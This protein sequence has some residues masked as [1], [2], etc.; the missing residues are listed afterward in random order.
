MPGLQKK[1]RFSNILDELAKTIS[2]WKK[3]R[4][5]VAF[6]AAA[7]GG[8]ISLGALSEY[9]KSKVRKAERRSE[10]GKDIPSDL[11]DAFVRSELRS[12]IAPESAIFAKTSAL[13][14]KDVLTLAGLGTAVGAVPVYHGFRLSKDIEGRKKLV[15]REKNILKLRR[16]L[17]A[18]FRRQILEDMGATEEDLQQVLTKT[19]AASDVAEWLLKNKGSI[20]ASSIGLGASSAAFGSGRREAKKESP[21]SSAIKAYEEKLKF[22]ERHRNLPVQI[23]DLPFTPEELIVL[24]KLRK[25][26][27]GM[28][29][30]KKTSTLDAQQLQS[31][32]VPADMDNPELK[33]LLSSI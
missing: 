27:S 4:R 33:T 13:S 12:D 23:S 32:E 18:V 30:K 10:L 20:L 1:A 9:L 29:P 21:G 16:E 22:L 8:G 31:V 3:A 2:D 17:D 6:G 14:T 11:V 26:V 25:D 19:S 7:M 15:A 28:H 24:Q 5:P